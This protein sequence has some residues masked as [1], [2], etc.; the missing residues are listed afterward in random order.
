M[1]RKPS[2]SSARKANIEKAIAFLKSD[3]ANV[4]G[5]PAKGNGMGV[6]DSG[7]YRDLCV[8]LCVCVLLENCV[9]FLLRFIGCKCYFVLSVRV[10]YIIIPIIL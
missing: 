5:D 10:S 9:M 6:V 2:S 7:Y 1:N 8:K 3:G 4:T